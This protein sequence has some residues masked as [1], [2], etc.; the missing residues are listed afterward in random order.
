M[1]IITRQVRCDDNLLDKEVP[2]YFTYILSCTK[3]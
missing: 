1:I 2:I 3:S